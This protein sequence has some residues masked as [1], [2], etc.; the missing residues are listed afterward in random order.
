VLEARGLT[1]YDGLIIASMIEREARLDEERP[2]IASVVVNRLDVGMLLQIDA[3]VVYA[4]GGTTEL[5]LD[6]LAID[7][8]YN[9]YRY[10]GLPP[11]PIAGVRLASLAAAAAPAETDFIYYVLTGEDGSH[12]FTDDFDEF[13]RFQE[14]ARLDGVIP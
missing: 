14:Q 7:S 13:L 12:S 10:P 2:I 5:T 3:T 4:V 9:T 1:P 11:T 8:P 6:D